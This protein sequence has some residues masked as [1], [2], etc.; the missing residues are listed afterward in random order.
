MGI[1]PEDRWKVAA[2]VVAI[3]MVVGYTFYNVSSRLSP[4]QEVA[5]PA[6][7]SVQAPVGPGVA[8][9]TPSSP[10]SDTDEA[11]P[12]RNPNPAD[13]DV[14]SGAITASGRDPFKPPVPTVVGPPAQPPP[15]TKPP[16]PS[17]TAR[18]SEPMLQIWSEPSGRMPG[19][20]GPVLVS[21][22][23]APVIEL[24][25]VIPG[26]PAIA[27][28]NVGGQ[29]VTRQEGEMVAEGYFIAK[30][31]EAGIVLKR[32]K[33]NILLNVGHSTQPEGTSR[34]GPPTPAPVPFGPSLPAQPGPS[35]TVLPAVPPPEEL[36]SPP[37][38]HRGTKTQSG[39]RG[40]MPTRT[41]QRSPLTTQPT[42]LRK[43]TGSTTLS[44]S[45]RRTGV[46]RRYMRRRSVRRAVHPRRAIRQTRTYFT[47]RRL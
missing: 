43:S 11:I 39:H 41:T 1:R 25:G 24:K 3:V 5:P 10:S 42:A 6:T 9:T 33:R 30:I 35:S 2:L 23:A 16:S 27:V 18:P 37:T 21:P 14:E 7:T 34:P 36:A 40:N 44:G 12:A 19:G 47:G 8:L 29:T 20:I 4:K 22:P 26:E 31:T 13:L 46:R 28:V 15:P 32:G 45:T 38:N 17:V